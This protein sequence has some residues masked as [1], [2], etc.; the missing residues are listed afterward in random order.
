[1]NSPQ[2]EKLNVCIVGAGIIGL[3]AAWKLVEDYGSNDIQIT[4]LSEHFHPQ[5]ISFCCGGLWEPYA[6][7][8]TSDKD[9]NRWGQATFDHFKEEYLSPNGV[10]NGVQLMTVYT[11]LEEHQDATPPSWA[12]IVHSFTLLNSEDLQKMGV[13]RKYTRG[14]SFGTYVV[15]QKYYEPHI[16]QKL[17]KAGVRFVQRKLDSLNEVVNEFDCVINCSG[18]GAYHLV[19]DKTMYPVRG[20]V[21][22]VK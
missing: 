15:D 14:Y 6:I 20:Q 1:M 19:P 3:C 10:K 13:P 16:T 4:V 22:R 12:S 17:Q 7:E 11:L 8:G 21:L 5:T 2:P 18:L 9:L